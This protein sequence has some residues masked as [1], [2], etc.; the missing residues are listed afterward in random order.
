MGDEVSEPRVV[1]AKSLI[2]SV[3]KP[4]PLEPYD[5]TTNAE[6]WLEEYEAMTTGAGW[7]DD[8]RAKQL[9]LYLKVEARNGGLEPNTTRS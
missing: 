8:T 4:R 1:Q 3:M 6:T 5:G 7:D 2:S 9:T